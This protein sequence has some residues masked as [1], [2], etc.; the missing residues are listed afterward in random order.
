MK[1]YRS[2]NGRLF[3]SEL[4]WVPE[5]ALEKIALTIAYDPFHSHGEEPRKD[6]PVV[7][8]RRRSDDGLRW[9][10]TAEAP[11]CAFSCTVDLPVAGHASLP[12]SVAVCGRIT[13][14]AVDEEPRAPTVTR[15]KAP[16]VLG[17]TPISVPEDPNKKPK[18]PADSSGRVHECIP[19]DILLK[20]VAVGEYMKANNVNV[21]ADLVS[22]DT[23]G[24]L[25]AERDE[26]EGRCVLAAREVV[27]LRGCRVSHYNKFLSDLAGLLTCSSTPTSCFLAVKRLLEAR[28]DDARKEEKLF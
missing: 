26:L 10:Y 2:S 8:S 19:T 6:V 21:L 22:R 12:K 15:S 13:Q 4:E 14:R 18:D 20:A 1:F 3:K 5:I 24:K 16:L 7:V 11:L 23:L 28:G 17:F 27:R 9:D 25:E